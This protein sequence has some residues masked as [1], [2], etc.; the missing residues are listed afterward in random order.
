MLPSTVILPSERK[1]VPCLRPRLSH[2]YVKDTQD[3]VVISTQILASS[4]KA[5]CPS[6]G[7]SCPSP[8]ALDDES[9]SLSDESTDESF[10]DFTFAS[11][12]H[13][14][15]LSLKDSMPWACPLPWMTNGDS[16]TVRLQPRSLPLRP[17]LEARGRSSPPPMPMEF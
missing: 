4:Y 15:G 6:A 12:V 1:D 7:T 17:N 5:D 11:E 13:F 16:T 9:C 3:Y 10:A 8:V 2:A 14:E